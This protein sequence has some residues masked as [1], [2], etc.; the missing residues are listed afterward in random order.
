MN[1]DYDVNARRAYSRH[2]ANDV[3][4]ICADLPACNLQDLMISYYKANV[5]VNESRAAYVQLTT[6]KHSSDSKVSI[7]WKEER[8]LRI[9]YII[10]CRCYSQTPVY[11]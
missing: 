7:L 6:M 10:Q 4:D 11:Y 8:R 9:N 2:D 3:D 5:V 1:A